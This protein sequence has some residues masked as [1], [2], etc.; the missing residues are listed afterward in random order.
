MC[1]STF[2]GSVE[3]ATVWAVSRAFLA[4]VQNFG[5]NSLSPEGVEGW[6][7]QIPK[8]RSSLI[9]REYDTR[10]ILKKSDLPKL[11]FQSGIFPYFTNALQSINDHSQVSNV[12][13]GQGQ[14]NVPKM[15][16]ALL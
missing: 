16:V 10:A 9:F 6:S 2:D 4:F 15:S 8:V 12:K 14:S 7:A 13:A 1:T 5:Q 3:R 11:P